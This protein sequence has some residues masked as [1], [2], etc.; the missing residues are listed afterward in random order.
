M[1]LLLT[2]RAFWLIQILAGSH[3]VCLRY[4]NNAHFFIELFDDI[5]VVELLFIVVVS[6][7]IDLRESSSLWE[8][9]WR[10]IS[11]LLIVELSWVLSIYDADISWKA[12]SILKWFF[13]W[14]FFRIA[15]AFIIISWLLTKIY[16]FQFKEQWII[17]FIFTVFLWLLWFL[18]SHSK[19]LIPNKEVVFNLLLGIN[20]SP[21]TTANNKKSIEF[22]WII[23][24]S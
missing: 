21:S 14:V 12:Y 8:S 7:G 24:K 3:D 17:S 10:R 19:S 22:Q 15:N 5:I 23:I 16:D 6:G 13:S 9:S 2:Q 4:L 18:H 20:L 1:L 11:W